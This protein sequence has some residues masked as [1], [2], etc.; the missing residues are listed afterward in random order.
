M[1]SDLLI[2]TRTFSSVLQELSQI[3]ERSSDGDRSRSRASEI[4]KQL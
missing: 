4:G 3:D 1:D 2:K